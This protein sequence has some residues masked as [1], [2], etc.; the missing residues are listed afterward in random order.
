MGFDY[1]PVQPQVASN[2]L[3]DITAQK[4]RPLLSSDFSSG[5]GGGDA[6]GRMRVSNPEM[7]FNSKQ[8]F[9]NQAIF[10]DDIQFSGTGTTSTH[11]QNT[12]STTLAVST[13]AGRRIRQTYMRF[14][15]QP[16][17]SQLIFITGVLKKSG[18]ST[19]ITARMGLFDDNNGLFLENNAGTIRVVR[20]T[21][22]TG[23]PTDNPV[24]QSSWNIDKLDGT[25]NSGITID[26]T[27][28]QILVIDFE[29]LG[30]GRVR[31]GFNIN[32][33]TYYVHEM[34][35]ANNLSNVYMS[36][37][38]LPIR[39]EIA[40]DGNGSASS[41]ECICSA[42]ISEGGREEVAVNG[43]ASTGGTSITATKLTTNAILAIRQKTGYIGTTID[44]LDVSLL[45]TSNDNYE[46]KLILNPSGIN[47]LTYTDINNSSIQYAMPASGLTKISGGYVIA[48][49]FA[50]AKTDIQAESLKSILKLGSSIT[51][52][53][54]QLVLACYPLG[55]SDSVVYGGINYREFI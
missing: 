10:F 13:S 33:I 29:W 12:A 42:V 47:G 41:L 16:S 8:I 32:G 30:V 37:P 24:A 28:T 48:G 52:L 17:K 54:D 2:H 46:W 25:G 50:Q 22:V 6:F 4:W 3:Y 7:I 40:N 36:T 53:R 34:L 15:Y 51:G 35:H 55:N 49:G 1:C 14:N 23:T 39:Y 11:N 27:K 38:N 18:G 19:G 9:D 20:R 45:T 26:F 31:F 21:N 5:G 43:Y 44:I